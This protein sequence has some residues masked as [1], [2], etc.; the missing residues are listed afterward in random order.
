VNAV[1]DA[2]SV[3]RIAGATATDI[4][5]SVRQRIERGELAPGSALPP[6]RT[7]ADELGSIATPSCPRI[8]C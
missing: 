2:S 5:D 8:V 1:P 6:V 7:L 4:A 3:L